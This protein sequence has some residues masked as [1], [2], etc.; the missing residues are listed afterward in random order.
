MV[1]CHALHKE[2]RTS[3]EGTGIKSTRL[4]KK[5]GTLFSTWF[6]QKDGIITLNSCRTFPYSKQCARDRKGG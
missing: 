2:Q 1:D 6:D 5:T 4:Q 3:V